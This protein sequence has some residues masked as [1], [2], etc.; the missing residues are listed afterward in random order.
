MKKQ[1]G[2]ALAVLLLLMPLSTAAA[3]DF[4]LNI[5]FQYN[6]VNDEGEPIA[7]TIG[8][9]IKPDISIGN[10]GIGLIG[11]FRFSFGG[12]A[13]FT[14]IAEDWIPDFTDDENLI[15]K[16]QTVAS[17]YLPLIRYVRY[18]F[19]GDP[20]Y[21]RFGELDSV[22]VG[23]GIFVNRYTNTALQPDLRLMG[24]QFDIDG[25]LFGFPYIGSRPSSAIC[26]PTT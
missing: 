11:S 15:D 13:G 16:A 19:K 25:E 8:V 2:F 17:T 24:A 12:D 21:A 7:N 9:N 14:F 3:N 4:D 6:L 18:G 26:Q 10:F 22:T 23:T 1:I 5:G 20:L